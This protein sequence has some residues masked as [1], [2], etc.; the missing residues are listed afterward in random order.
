MYRQQRH[1]ICSVETVATVGVTSSPFHCFTCSL[2]HLFTSSPC[3]PF[4]FSPFY[5]FTCSPSRA[6]LPKCRDCICS[7]ETIGTVRVTSSPLHPFTPPPLHLFTSSPLHLFS[8]SPLHLFI[9]SPLHDIG[10]DARN[11]EQF[12]RTKR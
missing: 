10:E 3:Q 9:S 12:Q 7:V 1:R 11:G 2:F 8:S 5:L 6:S 4:A